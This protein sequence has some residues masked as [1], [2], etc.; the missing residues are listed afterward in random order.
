MPDFMQESEYFSSSTGVF[1][2]PRRPQ[3]FLRGSRWQLPPRRL[4]QERIP[5][6]GVELKKKK[7]VDFQLAPF[8]AHLQ[9]SWHGIVGSTGLGWA[10]KG[11]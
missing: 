9:L 2:H 4:H 3:H 8:P 7:K 5:P 6:W 1:L 10:A 11:C